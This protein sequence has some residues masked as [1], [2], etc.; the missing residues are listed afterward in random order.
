MLTA[1]QTMNETMIVNYL[2]SITVFIIICALG[3]YLYHIGLKERKC[4]ALDMEMSGNVL[5]VNTTSPLFKHA[6][7][8][9]YVAT[10]MN[11]CNVGS[12]K[13]D[14]VDLCSLR[15][16]L[17]Q[18]V[19][20]LGCEI[21]SINDQ[22]VIAS[23]S[24]KNYCVKETFN[25][26]SF[27]DFMQTLKL[28]AFNG[29]SVPN[30]GDP[31]LLYLK[32]KSNNVPMYKAMDKIFK[33]YEDM[34]LGRDYSY[35]NG[36]RNLGNT[37]LVDL[38]GK[39]VIMVGESGV[40]GEEI[41]EWVNMS[42]AW[43]REET[44]LQDAEELKESSKRKMIV[45]RVGEGEDGKMMMWKGAGVQCIEVRSGAVGWRGGFEAKKIEAEPEIEDVA[46][47]KEEVSYAPRVLQSDYY[48]V[49]I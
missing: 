48:T 31:L 10:A 33:E 17:K 21:Y 49:Q 14:Y 25:Y 3:Y 27:R 37:P 44:E 26:V 43:L 36:G 11:C 4:A 8:D 34:L 20:C 28:D 35:M 18:G 22:P 7:K 19:R 23:S 16:W 32:I 1:V 5:P 9:Y 46:A 6:L 41:D 45:G 15:S 42:S 39:V 2:T 40:G 12:V 29:A 30:P 47:Q 38:M 24:S 13:N